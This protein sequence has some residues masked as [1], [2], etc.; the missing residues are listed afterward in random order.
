MAHVLILV[1]ATLNRGL[2]LTSQ[3]H[4]HCSRW[5]KQKMYAYLV[6]YLVAFLFFRFL[7]KALIWHTE[8]A[9]HQFL[10]IVLE[11]WANI[12]NLD[13][14][15]F[16]CLDSPS[17]LFCYLIPW[18]LFVHHKKNEDQ[19]LLY[20]LQYF[21]KLCVHFTLKMFQTSTNSLLFKILRYPL[22]FAGTPTGSTPRREA[23]IW[24]NIFTISE[25]LKFWV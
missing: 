20:C 15:S 5:L 10:M 1:T 7:S 16:K 19:T 13:T 22:W 9:F 3:L 23:R 18:Y 14:F 17:P 12:N 24:T 8:S 21:I 25:I 4:V 6:D 11:N 2:A